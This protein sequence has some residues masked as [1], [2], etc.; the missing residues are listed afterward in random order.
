MALD[1]VPMT[2][3]GQLKLRAELKRLKET[4]MPAVIVAIAEARAHGDLS[5]N[6]EYAA[7]RER[8]SF[9]K[10]RIDDI[11]SKLGRAQVIDPTTL[12]GDRVIFGATVTI[13]DPDTGK[14]LTYTIV[15]IDE[16]DIKAGTISV[17][18]P[19]ARGL[20]GKSVGDTAVVQAPGGAREYEIVDVRFGGGPE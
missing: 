18:S 20:I 4:E 11:E 3:A 10:G 5:E 19:I 8:Q 12:E 14:E 6:A 17:S 16:A 13:S 15:G 9:I 2:V 7:A 1:R